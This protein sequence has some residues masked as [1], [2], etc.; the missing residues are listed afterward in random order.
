MRKLILTVSLFV[1][2]VGFAQQIPN[3]LLKNFKP[4]ETPRTNCRPGT[5]YRISSNGV[6]YIVKD[7]KQIKSQ[8]SYDGTL[9]G[10]MTFS[11]KEI[12]TM[13]NL[14]FNASYITAE[15]EIKNAVREYTEQ[16]NVDLVLWENDV[17]EEI[18]VDDGSEYYIIRE[19]I[20][21]KEITFRFNKISV[22]LLHTGKAALKEKS[23]DGIDFP[24]E[25]KKKFSE[26]KRIFYLEEKIEMEY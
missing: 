16:T 12:L 13:L 5:V 7:I 11:N 8:T 20:A 22:K 19:T 25:I 1:T 23:G 2:V 17:A 4:F 26:E 9:I 3:S 21:T 18:M 14:D 6:K 15:V 24:F 10:Q